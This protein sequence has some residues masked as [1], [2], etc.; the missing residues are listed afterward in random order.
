M[1][2]QEIIQ[3]LRDKDPVA[4]HALFEKYYRQLTQFAKTIIKDR[5]EAEDI[6]TEAF[7][8][9]WEKNNHFESFRHLTSFLK[10]II[11]NACFNAIRKTKCRTDIESQLPEEKAFTKNEVELKYIEASILQVV[12][13]RINELPT[14]TREA[15]ILIHLK[16]LTYAETAR[17]M[18]VSEH[19]IRN[20]TYTALKTLR[21]SLDFEKIVAAVFLM[22][23]ALGFF[24]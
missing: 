13:D 11:K 12:Y 2:E 17:L 8:K 6:V 14:R 10:L 18:N 23:L 5:K 4:F 22:I 7:I 15:F 1:T 16:G 20:L 9:I 3:G 19:T 21:N 24:I